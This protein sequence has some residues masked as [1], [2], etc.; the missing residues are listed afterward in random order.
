VREHLSHDEQDELNDAIDSL[1][2]A[3]NEK[4]IVA[5]ASGEYENLQELAEHLADGLSATQMRHLRRTIDELPARVRE[6]IEI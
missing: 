4:L 6:E 5:L 1:P 2:S 3:L